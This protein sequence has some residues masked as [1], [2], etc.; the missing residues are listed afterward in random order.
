MKTIKGT[1]RRFLVTSVLAS[2]PVVLPSRLFG[3]QAPS[4]QIT[5]GF[6]GMGLQGMQR[7]LGNF[8]SQ[9]DAKVLAVCDVLKSRAEAAKKKVDAKYDT[10]DCAAYQDFR[11]LLQRDDLD[12]IVIST[13][14]HWHVPLS[15]AALA[16]GK[17]V[18]CEKPTLTIAEGRMLQQEV[19]RREAVFQWGIEDR[20]LI[21]YHRLAG[22]VRDGHIGELETI[23]VGLPGKQPFKKDE[24][25]PV[26]EGLDW[27][28]WLGPAPFHDYTPTRMQPQ[29]WRYIFD[30]SGGTITDWGSH[31]IDTA[32]IGAFVEDSGPLQVKGTCR[33][34]DP[35][36]W[37]TNVPVG[38]EL[39]YEYANGVRMIAK[40][41]AVDIRFEGSK[42]WVQCK[43]WNGKWLTSD[44]EVMR[45]SE[46]SGEA[47][48]WPLPPIEHRDFLDKIKSRGK[49]AYHVE[50][51]H[52]LSTTL[53]LGHLACATGQ[54]VKWDP[55]TGAFT[56]EHA[57][58]H[59]RHPIFKRDARNWEKA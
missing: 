27:N 30:Y 49:P 38:Y 29:N 4:K 58:D 48:Y 44:P 34:L 57:A 14:D 20:S 51:G 33:E 2:A 3:E 41:G 28:L 17:D 42:G 54:T 32:Q 24:V 26:P 53:H 15:M 11:E 5:L 7:N 40:D 55:G 31:I 13:P 39:E 46:F 18:F 9:K 8:L 52:R 21:R 16:A 47:K 36:K 12:A 10:H 59:A 23:H 22:W 1:R 45:I 19:D 50:A 25:A 37:Q 43:G 35:E 56:G 6:I